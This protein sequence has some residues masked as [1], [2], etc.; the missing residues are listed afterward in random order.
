MKP[1]VTHTCALNIHTNFI[2]NQYIHLHEVVNISVDHDVT[3]TLQ[4]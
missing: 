4:M 3:V 2:L 1:F